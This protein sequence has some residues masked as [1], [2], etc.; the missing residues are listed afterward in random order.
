MKKARLKRVIKEAKKRVRQNICL[1]LLASLG[2]LAG[3]YN[4]DPER[5][6]KVFRKSARRLSKKISPKMA[7]NSLTK[8][9]PNNP[10][11]VDQVQG[12]S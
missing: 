7:V 5:F 11:S 10:V 2:E 4:Q 1:S 3:A 8:P 9:E 6:K 12:I